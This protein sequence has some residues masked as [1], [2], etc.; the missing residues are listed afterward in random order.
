MI[1]NCVYIKVKPEAV[2][3]FIDATVKNHRESVK[4]AGNLRFDLICQADEPC[5]FMLYEAWESEDAAADHKKT[6]HY[7]IWRDEVESFMAEPRKG[8]KHYIIQPSDKS[9]W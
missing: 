2:S 1:V 7:L 8:V 3:G 5:R 4:E 6:A 9:Q